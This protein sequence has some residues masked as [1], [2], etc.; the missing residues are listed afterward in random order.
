MFV[1]LVFIGCCDLIYILYTG[2]VDEENDEPVAHRGNLL[3][4]GEMDD[5]FRKA[6]EFI[7]QVEE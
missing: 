5:F 2:C 6:C 7:R 4:E 3:V 1:S